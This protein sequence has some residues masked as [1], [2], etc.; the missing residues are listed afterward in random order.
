MSPAHL[1]RRAGPKYRWQLSS[2]KA[3]APVAPA[4]I[5][6]GW[7]LSREKS[8]REFRPRLDKKRPVVRRPS[9][10]AFPSGGGAWETAA[11]AGASP[12]W[13]EAARGAK[14]R[15]GSIAAVSQALRMV[16]SLRQRREPWLP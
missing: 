13:E 3:E 2:R 7:R 11:G 6:N 12:D 9:A 15:M 4:P 14:A 10:D 8:P 16:V 1:T 5:R